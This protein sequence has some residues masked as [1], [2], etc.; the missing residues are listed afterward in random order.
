MIL[1]SK[2]ACFIS[3]EDHYWRDKFSKVLFVFCRCLML[4]ETLRCPSLS[5]SISS[6][7]TLKPVPPLPAGAL[8]LS[9]PPA[10]RVWW[11]CP[12]GAEE[13]ERTR[14]LMARGGGRLENRPLLKARSLE[15]SKSRTLERITRG[16]RW[17]WAILPGEDGRHTVK[18]KRVCNQ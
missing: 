9:W 17:V 13:T 12:S 10:A 18:V 15:I 1:F 6:A 16:N 8:T 4:P 11:T 7:S 2:H 5:S 14:L 3:K